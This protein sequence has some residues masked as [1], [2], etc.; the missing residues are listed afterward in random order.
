MVAANGTITI[1]PIA[2]TALPVD[3]DLGDTLTVSVQTAAGTQLFP[4]QLVQVVTGAVLTNLTP[5]PVGQTSTLAFGNTPAGSKSTIA[6][7]LVNSG[8]VNAQ[9][10]CAPIPSPT[11]GFGVPAG[12]ITTIVAGAGGAADRSKPSFNRR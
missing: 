2:P 7:D 6:L 8:N 4:L 10:S 11:N 5:S 9:V 1:T 3:P 12:A